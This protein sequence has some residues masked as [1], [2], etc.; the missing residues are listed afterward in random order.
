[1]G[2]LP[3]EK[4]K[5]NE[6]EGR[7]KEDQASVCAKNSEGEDQ[8]KKH[9]AGVR[10]RRDASG[11]LREGTLWEKTMSVDNLRGGV[12]PVRVGKMAARL[13]SKKS[14]DPR[15]KKGGSTRGSKA[16][17]GGRNEKGGPRP[18]TGLPR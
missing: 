16:R 10:L 7:R 1:M 18:T 11:E 3:Q 14:L 8:K 9:Y 6:A 4:S 13:N 15:K 17:K 12:V 2:P 5:K